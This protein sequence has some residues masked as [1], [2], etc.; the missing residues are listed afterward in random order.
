MI[1]YKLVVIIQKVDSHLVV[2]KKYENDEKSKK[3]KWV[4]SDVFFMV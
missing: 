3:L 2:R 4:K 1:D